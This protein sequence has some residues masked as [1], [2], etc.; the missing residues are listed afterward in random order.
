MHV[1]ETCLAV[2][3]LAA[4]AGL[5]AAAAQAGSGDSLDAGD[6]REGAGW[7]GTCSCSKR[8]LQLLCYQSSTLLGIMTSILWAFSLPCFGRAACLTASAV[9]GC[10]PFAP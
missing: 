7:A 10:A 6:D 8:N 1:K 5:H 2:S 9:C 3:H 4:S